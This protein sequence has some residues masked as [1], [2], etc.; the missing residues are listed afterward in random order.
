MSPRISEE[1]VEDEHE[2]D[3]FAV[4]DDEMDFEPSVT[5]YLSPPPLKQFTIELSSFSPLPTLQI[6]D[7]S[8]PNL[9]QLTLKRPEPKS[10]FSVDSIST[11][12]SPVDSHFDFT[13]S[14]SEC[15]DDATEEVF[16]GPITQSP[17]QAKEERIRTANAFRGYSLPFDNDEDRKL[18]SGKITPM[19]YT[20]PNVMSSHNNSRET[21]E[22]EHNSEP[23]PSSNFDQLIVDMGYLGE[24]IEQ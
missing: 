6:V 12:M 18:S 3:N 22:F 13:P 14:T 1:I 24:M 5:T 17:K 7:K 21:F 4:V 19:A 11:T 20:I 23:L 8:L 16:F 2:D 10:H 9:P 15:N